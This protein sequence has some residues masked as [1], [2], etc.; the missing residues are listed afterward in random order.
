MLNLLLVDASNVVRKVGRRLFSEFGFAVCEAANLHEAR[1]FCK[2]G[3]LP[4]YIIIDEA[5]AES[6]EFIA[7][8]RKIPLGKNVFVYC[9]LIEVDFKKMISGAKVGVNDFLLKPFNRE[10]LQFALRDLP[11][12]KKFALA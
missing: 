12:M 8:L 9:L 3:S 2:E 6:L 10:T 11:Q 5:M 7:D 4:D 1:E